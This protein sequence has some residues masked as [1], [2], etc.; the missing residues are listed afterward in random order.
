MAWY[1]WV[2]IGVATLFVI[3]LAVAYVCFKIVF[4]TPKRNPFSDG[5]EYQLPAGKAYAP[6]REQIKEWIKTARALPYEDVA[7]TSFDGLTLR[8]K[9]YECN[10]NGVTELLF[11]G[12][13]G[14]GERDLSGGIERCFALNRNALVVDQR[15]CASSDG[16]VVTFGIRERR[17]CLTWIRF[18]V[19]KFGDDCQLI[20]TGISMGAATVLMA[21]AEQ[22][23]S[24]VKCVLADCGYTSA[25][26]IIKKVIKDM[27][28]SPT[29]IYPFVWLGAKLYGG[30]DLHETS[31]IQAV[32]KIKIPVI[33]IH[34]EKDSFVP[35]Y[36]SKRLFEDC[37]APKAFLSLPDAEHGLAY[38]VD[39][40]KYLD[41]LRDFEK[42][43]KK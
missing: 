31:P 7:V 29:L 26:E 39:K 12:Y 9:Y 10:P 14:S 11:H 22:L 1:W 38:P 3:V 24:N 32:K 27:K 43:W 40:E 13:H 2:A 20:I 30:F 18:A 19:Q 28:L 34:G 42:E 21:A 36:M 4:C 35:C 41:A 33:F 15:G 16:N 5:G 25:K 17:D 8:G 37:V 23:P 6:F